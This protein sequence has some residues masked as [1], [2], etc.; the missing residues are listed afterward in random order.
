MAKIILT[1]TSL[2][3]EQA[4][5]LYHQL[6]NVLGRNHPGQLQIDMSSVSF[7]RPSGVMALVIAA[8]TWQEQ[9]GRQ[10]VLIQV[11]TQVHAYLDRVDLFSTCGEF[12]E[13]D[14]ELAPAQRYSRSPESRSVVELLPISGDIDQNSKG[15]SAAVRRVSHVLCERYGADH[16]NIPRLCTLVAEL[17][18]NITHSQ[19]SGYLLV[20]SYADRLDERWRVSIAIGDCGIGIERSLRTRRSILQTYKSQ[21]KSGSD[22]IALSLREGIT[23]LRSKRG[24]GLPLVKNTVRDWKGSLSIRSQGSR[25]TLPFTAPLVA[26]D[27]L[28]IMPG[29]QVMINAAGVFVP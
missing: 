1:G 27:D 2:G 3:S 4:E 16:P 19:D 28:P 26:H 24:V 14:D 5:D 25:L 13:T 29:T 23:S 8:K 11:Q 17:G 7:V 20:Q 9:T 18:S 12:I 10:T 15:V 21:L 6:H 22:F